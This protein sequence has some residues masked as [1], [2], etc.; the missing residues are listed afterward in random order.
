MSDKSRPVADALREIAAQDLRLLDYHDSSAARWAE[1]RSKY[2]SLIAGLNQSVQRL[3]AQWFASAKTVHALRLQMRESRLKAERQLATVVSA[4][5]RQREEAIVQL[6][7]KTREAGELALRLGQAQKQVGNTGDAVR[8][9]LAVI[10]GRDEQ[11]RVRVQRLSEL[12]GEIERM[13]DAISVENNRHAAERAERTRQMVELQEAADRAHARADAQRS[14]LESEIA[15]LRQS[16]AQA[17]AQQSALESEMAQVRRAA[18]LA[19]T[20]AGA[21]RSGLELKMEALREAAN[22]AN[23][24]AVKM[25]GDLEIKMAALQ[26]T[27]TADNVR[28]DKIR[29]DLQLK[30]AALQAAANAATVRADEIR[31]K[32]AAVQ[33][34]ANAANVRADKM[35]AQIKQQLDSEGKAFEN[36]RQLNARLQAQVTSLTDSQAANIAQLKEQK[37]NVERL[38]GVEAKQV[39][40]ARQN[41]IAVTSLRNE[42]SALKIAEQKGR[43]DYQK[44]LGDI[45]RL[46]GAL[47]KES[48]SGIELITQIQTARAEMRVLRQAEPAKSE[49]IRS[50]S[51]SE[52]DYKGALIGAATDAKGTAV[53]TLENVEDD[54]CARGLDN[55][56]RHWIGTSDRVTAYDRLQK[57]DA[58][59]W[60]DASR[61]CSSEPDTPAKTSAQDANKEADSGL[62]QSLRGLWT[63]TRR[64]VSLGPLA[65]A[66]TQSLTTEE[67]EGRRMFANMIASRRP[68]VGYL[69]R[70][71]EN[72]RIAR[73]YDAQIRSI[74]PRIK[75]P[76]PIPTIVGTGGVVT[77]PDGFFRQPT[78]TLSPTAPSQ[79][80]AAPP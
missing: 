11:I 56:T 78:T 71:A 25:R 38:M 48:K 31:L 58:E 17:T 29:S 41:A 37:D 5:E 32:M 3:E 43:N 47:Q 20:R 68:L 73:M 40:L 45:A 7:L 12:K 8:T 33:E 77:L 18:S 10:E 79:S 69:L 80:A 24:S 4:A 21:E 51:R 66:Q 52:Y 15:K 57:E 26:E 67:R 74:Q 75:W 65:T 59:L 19:N 6:G 22:A 34:A 13:Q 23:V 1:R 61:R 46:Q 76:T 35:R 50:G 42:I 62:P 28:A 14:A 63:H 16:A 27:A 72:D 54:R 55:L 9:L 39:E 2:E 70:K 64:L 60:D 30:M 44:S 49:D 53:S 36:V